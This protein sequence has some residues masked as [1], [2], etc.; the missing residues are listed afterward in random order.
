M[1]DLLA[2]VASGLGRRKRVAF[3]TLLIVESIQTLLL[4]GVVVLF[5]PILVAGVAA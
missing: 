4:A 3:R 1:G 2:I 5:R